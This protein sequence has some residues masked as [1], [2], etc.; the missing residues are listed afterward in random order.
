[1]L[2]TDVG[3]FDLYSCI[4][5]KLLR[6]F[7][8]ISFSWGNLFKLSSINNPYLSMKTAKLI[9]ATRIKSQIELLDYWIS[10]NLFYL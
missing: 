5:G 1:M 6:T 8:L 9:S 3:L 2:K 10:I 7:S 4:P